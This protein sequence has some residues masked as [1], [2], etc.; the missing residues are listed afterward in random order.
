MP[1]GNPTQ[2][3]QGEG[4]CGGEPSAGLVRGAG[5]WEMCRKNKGE[6]Q[7]QGRKEDQNFGLTLQNL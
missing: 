2:R 5:K 1:T 3:L 4:I 7:K 6:Q